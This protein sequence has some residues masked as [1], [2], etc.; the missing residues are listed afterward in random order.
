MDM[1]PHVALLKRVQHGLE[2]SLSSF[3]FSPFTGDGM[4]FLAV[5][6][7]GGQVNLIPI[8]VAQRGDTDV[9]TIVIEP[10]MPVCMHFL[11]LRE[12]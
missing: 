8:T 1:R 4:S 10:P 12:V 3:A 2:H 5:G 7:M 11:S 6:S 9:P